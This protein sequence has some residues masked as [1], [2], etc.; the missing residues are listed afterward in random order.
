LLGWEDAA[1][2]AEEGVVFGSHLVRHLDG[3]SLP[4]ATLAEELARSR[5]V[6]EAR[7]GREVRAYAAPY[8]ALD[9]RFA[10]LAARCGYHVGFS[11]RPA[12]AHL[13]DSPLMLPRIEVGGEWDLDVFAAALE[14]AR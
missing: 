1:A 4:T 10:R 13:A 8:G 2:L 6:L 9:E 14:I 7:L 12:Q 5:A 11:T 3:L